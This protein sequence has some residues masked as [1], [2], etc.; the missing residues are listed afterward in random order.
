VKI[1][2]KGLDED[3]IRRLKSLDIYKTYSKEVKIDK[4][5]RQRHIRSF[6]YGVAS[7]YDITGVTGRRYLD[8]QRKYLRDAIN[9][10]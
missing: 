8:E 4:K 2:I 10:R 5:Y 6:L 9:A 1:I 3:T 7:A